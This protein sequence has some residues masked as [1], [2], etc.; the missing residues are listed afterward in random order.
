MNYIYNDLT[1]SK[2]S[3]TNNVLIKVISNDY[4]SVVQ[5]TAEYTAL[6]DC[7][8]NAELVSQTDSCPIVGREELR[9][10]IDALRTRIPE[11]R[12][13]QTQMGTAVSATRLQDITSQDALFQ[14]ANGSLADIAVSYEPSSRDEL[15][16][17]GILPLT[18]EQP[19]PCGTFLFLEGVRRAL[20]SGQKHITAFLVQESLTPIK[21]SVDYEDYRQL[22]HVF[23]E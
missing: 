7:V 14:I 6:A 12:A 18:V 23:A 20:E 16:T 10:I 1:Y 13:R 8:K 9:P 5:K 19:L 15:L 3:I 21:V 22:Q 4:Q 11:L 17:A 2:R